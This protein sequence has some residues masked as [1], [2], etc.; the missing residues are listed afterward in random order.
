MSTNDG[1]FWG[2]VLLVV[3]LALHQMTVRRLWWKT[4][5]VLLDLTGIVA[6]IYVCVYASLGYENKTGPLTGI[7]GVNLGM[8]Q[9]DV[10]IALGTPDQVINAEPQDEQ[11]SV[12][13]TY[14]DHSKSEISWFV[15]LYDNKVAIVCATQSPTYNL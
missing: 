7:G 2:A 14:L 13:L 9:V 1:I 15:R 3:C 4:V 12:I 6:I 5:R 8:R 11:A 10:Q